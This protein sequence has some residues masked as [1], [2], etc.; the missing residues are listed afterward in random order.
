VGNTFVGDFDVLLR[1]RV[2][3]EIVV[4]DLQER[5]HRS[6]RKGAAASPPTHD[7]KARNDSASGPEE[8]SW[9]E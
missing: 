6:G 1:V 7:L 8:Q 5:A 2:S 9:L 4:S 3:D